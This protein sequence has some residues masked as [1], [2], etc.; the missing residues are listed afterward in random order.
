MAAPPLDP[1]IRAPRPDADALSYDFAQPRAVSDRQLRGAYAAHAALAKAVSADWEAAL[2]TTVRVEVRSIDR[3]QA[4]DFERSR[5]H[6][7]ALFVATIGE[8]GPGV[9]VEVPPALAL[10]LVERHLGGSDPLGTEARALSDLEQTVV[11]RHWL[12]ALW[13][14]FAH[15]WGTVPP[16]PTRF[17][18]DPTVLVLSA[19]DAP[20]LVVDLEVTVGDASAVLSLCYPPEALRLL[21]GEPPPL[22]PATAAL[23][24]LPPSLRAELGRV[25]LT[26]SDLLALTPGDI[27]PL[28]APVDRPVQVWVGDRL[29]FQARAGVVGTRMALDVLTPPAPPSDS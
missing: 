12:P 3:V 2:G 11:E 27:V 1:I 4:V 19:P 26:V 14:A 25:R 17:V 18:S 8:A 21:L 6:P 13:A 16:R 24:D 7:T 15:A 29:Q 5:S 20:S 10:F 22:A 28:N 23:D 9:V